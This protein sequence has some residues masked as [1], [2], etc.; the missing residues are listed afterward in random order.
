M[1]S[2]V[3]REKLAWRRW[4]TGWIP[5][6][7]PTRGA[8]ALPMT[9][10][11]EPV[12]FDHDDAAARGRAHGELWRAEI[13]ELAEIRCR[14]M[15]HDAAAV[16]VRLDRAGLEALAGA[17]LPLLA[18]EEPEA[19]AELLGIAT[20]SDLSPE[21]IVVL[22]HYTDL[23]DVLFSPGAL[24]RE[25][26]GCT[27]IYLHGREGPT[28]G[29]T[30]DMHASAAPYVRMMR[31]APRHGGTEV[32]C[33]TLVGCLALAGIGQHGVAVT[34][35][36]LCSTDARV[37][38]VWPA[39]V[40][41][42]LACP[43][44][45]AAYARLRRAPLGSGHHY[46]IADG[47]AFYGVECSGAHKVLTQSGPKAA[48]LHTN[49]CFDPVLRTCEA[50]PR[51]TTTFARLNMATTL[52]AQQRPRDLEGLWSLLGSHDGEPR[53]ICTHVDGD[54]PSASRTCARIAM[55]P[56]QGRMRVALGCS[57]E[58]EPLELRLDRFEAEAAPLDA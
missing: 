43:D 2:G 41:S 3:G 33:L 30:W 29:Q 10:P 16:G 38:L 1:R 20:G 5:A 36:N 34:I 4:T 50:V 58:G 9:H 44:A 45:P 24:A 57:R 17:H 15:L 51:V 42:L 14:L 40:R 8:I 19:H 35:N 13:H 12:C 54:D 31:I 21:R 22:N 55:L 7:E 28:L 11:L 39:L 18:R 53:S 25:P 56:A 46:M 23:R 48:H 47:H 32:L 37:G 49:H 27:A 6:W 52:Y 26:D